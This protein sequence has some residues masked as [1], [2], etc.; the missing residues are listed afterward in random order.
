M[1]PA[2]VRWLRYAIPALVGITVGVLLERYV[3][4]GRGA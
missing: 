1:N 4:Q 3:W 2:F